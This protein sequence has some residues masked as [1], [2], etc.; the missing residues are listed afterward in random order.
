MRWGQALEQE[1]EKVAA[2]TKNEK[3]Q[4]AR[5]F[6]VLARWLDLDDSVRYKSPQATT[7]KAV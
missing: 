6:Q 3:M 4:A 7:D 5:R 1:M 2:G